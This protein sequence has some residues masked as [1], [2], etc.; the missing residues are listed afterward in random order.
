MDGLLEEGEIGRNRP[1]PLIL[2]RSQYNITKKLT[3]A[4]IEPTNSSSDREFSSCYEDIDIIRE[5]SEHRHISF[6]PAFGLTARG[7]NS[8]RKSWH[9]ACFVFLTTTA[10]WR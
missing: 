8:A 10:E 1:Q 5:R 7:Q 6:L 2:I 9:L 3:D 4:I